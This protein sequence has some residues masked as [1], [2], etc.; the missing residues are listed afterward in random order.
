MHRLVPTASGAP[1]PLPSSMALALAVALARAVVCDRHSCL[2]ETA[3]LSRP[4]ACALCA[5]VAF[6]AMPLAMQWVDPPLYDGLRMVR[7]GA[8]APAWYEGNLVAGAALMEGVLVAA[9][10]LCLLPARAV[11]RHRWLPALVF[12]LGVAVPLVGTACYLCP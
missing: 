6:L 4:L 9:A 2:N 3:M 7:P 10:V 12:L 5:L 1:R 11:A 8:G